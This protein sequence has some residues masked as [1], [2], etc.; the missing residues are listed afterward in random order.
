MSQTFG[1]PGWTYNC[2]HFFYYIMHFLRVNTC[3]A[4]PA[5]LQKVGMTSKQE[6]DIFPPNMDMDTLAMES[7]EKSACSTG[8]S[9]RKNQ[10]ISIPSSRVSAYVAAFWWPLVLGMRRQ[11]MPVMFAYFQL[12]WWKSMNQPH[13]SSPIVWKYDEIWYGNM[14]LDGD[15]Q[16][17][18]VRH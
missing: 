11:Q 17:I 12:H 3:D 6:G 16:E 9:Q 14:V 13:Q 18:R 1:V 8:Q 4:Y 10:Q 5:W 2:C 7:H 15:G